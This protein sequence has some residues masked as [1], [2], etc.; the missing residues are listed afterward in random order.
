MV[1][2]EDRGDWIVLQVVLGQVCETVDPATRAESDEQQGSPDRLH[3]RPSCP[4]QQPLSLLT[5]AVTDASHYFLGTASATW[6]SLRT[7]TA[8]HFIFDFIQSG[9]A[10]QV[11]G[12]SAP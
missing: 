4:T 7:S 11:Q 6:E 5:S 9:T 10:L 12:G 1:A 3:V 8:I 2:S